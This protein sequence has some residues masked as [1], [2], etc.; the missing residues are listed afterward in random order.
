MSGKLFLDTGVLVASFSEIDHR[1]RGIARGLI[2]EALQSHSA[3]ID[4]LIAREFCTIAREQFDQPMRASQLHD[5]VRVV[6]N[7]LC[8]PGTAGLDQAHGALD[9]AE[10]WSLSFADA[11]VLASAI[12]IGCDIVVSDRPMAGRRY[13]PVDVR[14][15][16]G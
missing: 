11:G 1:R 3:V 4:S 5:F 7:P 15:P 12:R 13:G 10:R 6:L 14:D 2:R 16:F 8:V 9:L